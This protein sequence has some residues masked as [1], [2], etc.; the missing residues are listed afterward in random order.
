MELGTRNDEGV[1]SCIATIVLLLRRSVQG[2]VRF[3]TNA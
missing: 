2:S 1:P 3:S